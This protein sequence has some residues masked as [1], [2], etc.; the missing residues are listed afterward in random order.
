MVGEERI[1]G[2]L[3]RTCGL[4]YGGFTTLSKQ[5]IPPQSGY[6]I[7]SGVA[8]SPY[9]SGACTSMQGR[10]LGARN[11]AHGERHAVLLAGIEADLERV[12][13]RL[14]QWKIKYQHR[15]GL[16]IRHAGGWLAKLNGAFS[17]DQGGAPFID[18]S[19]SH[20]MLP[21][22]GAAAAHSEHEV[23]PRVHGW[24]CWHPYVLEQAQH[25]Q[26]R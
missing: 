8:K 3:N 4:V 23:R 20:R 7:Q 13:P 14:G 22:F 19:D 5:P 9:F 12:L 15:P 10:A 21:D 2:V 6:G 18:K 17:F 16:D 26:R 11:L 24:K 1:R 25:R